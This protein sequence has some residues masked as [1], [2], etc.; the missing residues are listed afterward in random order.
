MGLVSDLLCEEEYA[1]IEQ[2]ITDRMLCAGGGR[3][4]RDTCYGDSGGPL[5]VDRESPARAPADFVLVGL[6]DFGNGCAQSGYP[7]VYT[8][9]ANP[10]IAHFLASGSGRQ[11]QPR[12][13][14]AR[15]KKKRRKHRHR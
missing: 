1:A 10:E 15:H 2:S 12:A 4:R 9:I 6:V 14:Q 7:G 8:R 11:L 3:P 13:T 5:V